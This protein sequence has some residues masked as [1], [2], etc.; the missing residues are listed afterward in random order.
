MPLR[1]LFM[2]Y[3]DNGYYLKVVPPLSD[4]ELMSLDLSALK[5]A[6]NKTIVEWTWSDLAM[7]SQ[8]VQILGFEADRFRHDGDAFERHAKALAKQ[9]G[10]TVLHKLW[11]KVDITEVLPVFTQIE[12]AV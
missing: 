5:K 4:D 1:E 10:D 2:G 3:T 7:N 8:G 9:I 11:Y 6:D 12:Q